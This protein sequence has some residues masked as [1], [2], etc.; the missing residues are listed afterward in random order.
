MSTRHITPDELEEARNTL[1]KAA[2][3]HVA[4]LFG[5]ELAGVEVPDSDCIKY[6]V[7]QD[8]GIELDIKKYLGMN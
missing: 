1:T 6:I 5:P 7:E 3:L 4:G 2:M 8:A